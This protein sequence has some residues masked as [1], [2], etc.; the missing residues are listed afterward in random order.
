MQ[1]ILRGARRRALPIALLTAL[2]LTFGLGLSSCGDDEIVFPNLFLSVTSDAVEGGPIDRLELIFRKVEDG[3]LVLFGDTPHQFD[4]PLPQSVDISAGPYVISLAPGSVLT[5]SAQAVVWGYV[6][7]SEK[8]AAMWSGTVDLNAAAQTDVHLSAL[9]A[10]CDADNDGLK[11]CSKPGCCGA[12]EQLAGDCDDANDQV[13]PLA[14]LPACIACT[15]DPVDFNCDGKGDACLDV[16]SDQFADCVEGG[17]ET[18]CDCHPNNPSF[19]PEAGEVCDGIDNNCNGE[20]DEGLVG[21]PCTAGEA[22]QQCEGVTVCQGTD[23]WVCDAPEPSEEVCDGK[24]N[25]CNGETDEGLANCGGWDGDWDGD[26]ALGADDCNNFDS[27]FHK[28][29]I[30]AGCCDPALKNELNAAEQLK[31]CDFDCD[32]TATFCLDSDS[33]FDGV[34]DAVELAACPAGAENDPNVYPKSLDGAP[35]APEKCGD[36]V[37]Q[38]CEGADLQCEEDGDNDDYGTVII[39]GETVQYDCDDTDPL[40]YP[41]APERCNGKDDDCNGIIDDGNPLDDYADPDNGNKCANPFNE[42]GV[43]LDSDKL[44]DRV[45][46]HGLTSAE[47]PAWAAAQVEGG[48]AVD[49]ICVDFHLPPAQEIFC[50]ALDDDCDGD[51]DEDFDYVE[52]H[53]AGLKRKKGDACGTGACVTLAEAAGQTS[54][55][56]CAPDAGNLAFEAQLTCSS[57][58]LALPEDDASLKDLFYCDNVDNDCDGVTDSHELPGSD[59]DCNLEGECAAA[60]TVKMLCS[61]GSWGCDYGS[62]STVELDKEVHCDALDNDCDGGTDE[63]FS[64]EEVAFSLP[65]GG[66]GECGPGTVVCSQTD[67]TKAT[68]SSNIDGTTPGVTP[69]ICDNKDNDCDSVVDN[70]IAFQNTIKSDLCTDA[71]GPDCGVCDG[72]GECGAGIVVCASDDTVATCSTDIFGTA[73]AGT[74]EICDELDNDCDGV[75]DNGLTHQNSI[76]GVLCTEADGPDCGACDGVGE[77]GTGTVVCAQDG[78]GT[79]TCSTNPQGTAP[80]VATEVCDYKDND[81]DGATDEE[82]TWTPEGG[83]AAL[84]LEAVCNGIGECGTGSVV[85][86]DV[87][88]DAADGLKVATCSTNPNGPSPQDTVEVCDALD[89]DCDGT[90]DDGLMWNGVALTANCNGVGECG[91]GKVECTTDGTKIATCSTNPNGSKAEDVDEICDSKDNDCNG[92]ADDNTGTHTVGVICNLAGQCTKN[93]V[94]ATCVGGDNTWQCD[95]SNVPQYEGTELKCDGLDNDCDGATDE[96]TIELD[97]PPCDENKTANGVCV[98]FE[99]TCQGIDGWVCDFTT[100]TGYVEVEGAAHCDNKDNDCDNVVDDFYVGTKGNECK[101]GVGQCELVGEQICNDSQDGLV[102]SVSGALAGTGCNDNN[103]CTHSD[104]CGGGDASACAGTPYTCAPDALTCTT[105]TCNGD[106]TCSYVL[107]ADTCLISGVC[108]AKDQLDPQNDCQSCQPGTKT[109]GFTVLDSGTECDDFSGCTDNDAC[110]GSGTCV[111][112]G[113]NPCIDGLACTKDKCTPIPNSTEF[114][115]DHAELLTDTC[116][117]ANQCYSKG[118][119]NPANECQVCDPATAPQAWTNKADLT[120]C[121]DGLVCTVDDKC[122]GGT[123]T[124]AEKDCGDGNECT[125]DGCD[126]GVVGGCTYIQLTGDDCIDDGISCTYDMC[127][128]GACGHPVKEDRCL[129]AGVCYFEGD[130]NAAEACLECQNLTADKAWSNIANGTDCEDGDKCTENDKCNG[131]GSCV[132]GGAVDCDDN[133]PCT[134]N[135]CFPSL[136]CQTQ[137]LGD[138]SP[139]P[140]DGKG[141]TVDQCKSGICDHKTIVSDQCLVAGECF[142]EN[143]EPDDNDC[144]SCVPG[145]IQ[146]SLTNKNNGTG[147]DA[148]DNGCTA[149]DQCTAGTCVAGGVPNCTSADDE[150]NTGVCFSTGANAHSCNKAPKAPG[151]SCTTADALDC[152]TDACDTSGVCKATLSVGCLIDGTCIAES[153]LHPTNDCKACVSATSDS[154]YSNLPAETECA[155]DNIACTDDECNG[156]GVCEHDV[157]A[158]TCTIGESCFAE[159]TKNPENEC[160]SCQTA[161]STTAWTN[162]GQGTACD[163]ESPGLA[164]TDDVCDANG[165]CKHNLIAG[166]CLISVAATPTCFANNA[167]DPANECKKCDSGT[168]NFFVNRGTS[169]ACTADA[170]ACTKDHCDG[171]GACVNDPE[172]VGTPCDADG[173]ACTTQKCALGAVCELTINTGKCLVGGTCYNTDEP[174]SVANPCTTC[175]PGSTQTALTALPD[176]TD[177]G[178]CA[179]CSAGSCVADLSQD[180]DCGDCGVCADKDDCDPQPL[181]TEI[182]ACGAYKCDGTAQTCPTECGQDSDCSSTHWCNGTACQLK[183]VQGA[184]CTASNECDTNNCSDSKC[185][186]TAC[187]SQCDTCTTG[188]CV[189]VG[190]GLAPQAPGCSGHL[191]DAGSA[192]CPATCAGDADCAADHYCNAGFDCVPDQANGES[193]DDGDECTSTFCADG[194]CCNSA[195]GGA[196]NEC[197]SGACTDIADGGAPQTSCDGHLCDGDVG[198]CPTV[199]GDDNDCVSTSFCNGSTDCQADQGAGSSCEDGAE[200]TS[201][202]CSDGKC[203]DTACG[204]ACDECSTGACLP[205]SDG[206]APQTSCN[207]YVCDGTLATCPNSCVGDADCTLGNFCNGSN[208]CVGKL[209]NGSGCSGNGQCTNGKCVDGVCCDDACTGTCERCDTGTVGTCEPEGDGTDQVPACGDLYCNGAGACHATCV[210]DTDCKTGHYCSGG[211]CTDLEANGTVCTADNECSSDTCVDDVCCNAACTDSCQACDVGGFIGICTTMLDETVPS[212]LCGGHLCN[213]TFTTCPT[214]CSNDDDCE[215]ATHY[216]GGGDCKLLKVDGTACGGGNECESDKCID[217]VC[218]ATGCTGECKACDVAGFEGTC[219]LVPSGED[220]DTECGGYFCNGTDGCNSACTL[221]TQCKGSHYCNGA[222]CEADLAN[223][224]ACT[225]NEECPNNFCVDDV[226]CNTACQFGCNVCDDTGNEGTCTIVDAGTSGVDPTCDGHLCDGL[227]HS[228]QTTCAAHT[229][230]ESTHYCGAGSDCL[231][232]KANGLGCTDNEECE[233]NNCDTGTCAAL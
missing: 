111:G 3:K 213:G 184:G 48:D 1:S 219:T 22:G 208:E 51:V 138:A 96:S 140:D 227:N 183:S 98:G 94:L 130:D 216:C 112:E 28:G 142:D 89:N 97:K 45:C 25:N 65:C 92:L 52:I 38:D 41:G 31:T 231:L 145:T 230:C 180:S 232:D 156:S 95:Y 153:A 164:C 203:C 86:A 78:S 72:V 194:T 209:P 82:Q 80:Q 173:L 214:V 14:A 42:A 139:C 204:A 190:D 199:C 134:A 5:G 126:N 59:T 159:G 8:P 229:G 9:G 2:S 104:Q 36:G 69:E 108:Y 11:D 105:D 44:G 221:D 64:Y 185:C 233:T 63:D 17:C 162:L 132:A 133:N 160:Q 6:K 13:S 106:D 189:L 79:A 115:C 102:C 211:A 85:C 182:G 20:T 188:T 167:S 163:D 43:C 186:D 217:D 75:A 84:A 148:D 7:G 222:T 18:D 143:E 88:D 53:D 135:P 19:H 157:P 195:C 141:C 62:I 110:N 206:G 119:E 127:N 147:C 137:N 32:G 109:D 152:T 218:C 131:S 165:V 197:S 128:A 116:K 76:K 177:C 4:L 23:K 178:D 212:P 67:D 220:Q 154:A 151:T 124:T 50:D 91:A 202:F 24:D 114:D 136:G 54:K 39:G 174:I 158:A 123:C 26:G 117:I 10:E 225:K 201:T 35:G 61:A 224:A 27:K 122:V 16:D 192:A 93:N 161:T 83:G 171:G 12:D 146:T 66:V 166:N 73:P 40:V 90:P 120:K 103:A 49:P 226:C 118:E 155:T 55:V 56:V 99:P 168:P 175:Q 179:E 149:N 107:V 210:L 21:E 172:Q 200:C 30:Y 169:E 101:K 170:N 150:C 29:S 77:C 223:A 87:A 33:D 129:I 37:S 81:C 196:C 205:I 34:E 144:V 58:G 121:D 60:A 191:C 207:A 15:A 198:T 46:A 100:I 71:D 176:T 113:E 181:G 68:C 57:L 187:G 70:G 193:C 125:T 228:C 215:S 74:T 47:L